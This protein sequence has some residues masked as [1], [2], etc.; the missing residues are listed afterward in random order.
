MT[1]EASGME[2]MFQLFLKD[3]VNEPIPQ[4]SFNVHKG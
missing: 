4:E 3:E 1:T 2:L